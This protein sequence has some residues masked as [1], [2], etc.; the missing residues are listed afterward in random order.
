MMQEENQQLK[1]LYIRYNTCAHV[2]VRLTTGVLRLACGKFL[3]SSFFSNGEGGA[4]YVLAFCGNSTS[5]PLG[6]ASR[7]LR[8][9][10][11]TASKKAPR[12]R[13]KRMPVGSFRFRRIFSD[14]C[15]TRT[16][17]ERLA[18]VPPLSS[19]GHAEDFLENP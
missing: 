14:S 18:L 2:D 10:S 6:I 9:K 17:N 11:P 8:E 7:H 3:Y 4:L 19:R 1:V 12:H 5:R 13:E 16:M 15:F